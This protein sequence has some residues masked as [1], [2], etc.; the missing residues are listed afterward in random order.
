MSRYKT[1]K[2]RAV[3]IETKPTLTDQSQASDTDINV[4]IARAKQGQMAPGAKT[5][6]MYEDFASLPAD[7]REAIEQAN[8]VQRLRFKLPEALR[9]KPVE[10]LISLT[11][12]QLKAIV[13]PPKEEKKEE[14]K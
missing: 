10:E 5:A 6:P 3:Y 4:I 8:S 7:L 12:E 14:A 9:E 1:N 11:A 2:A 13:D